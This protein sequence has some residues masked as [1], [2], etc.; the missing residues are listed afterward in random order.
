MDACWQSIGIQGDR[1]CR[2]LRAHIHCRNCPTFKDAARAFL[3]RSPEADYIDEVTGLNTNMSGGG[4]AG[5][6]GAPVMIFRLGEEW[7]ALPVRVIDHIHPPSPVRKV[8]HRLKAGFRG[9]A[10]IDGQIELCMS[11]HAVLDIESNAGERNDASR[12]WLMLKMGGERWIA[13]VDEVKGV[14]RVH[15]AQLQPL[16]ATLERSPDPACTGVFQSDGLRVSLLAPD[17]LLRRFRASLT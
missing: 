8:P 14:A 2:E 11:L 1:S 17:P 5:E 7:H 12:R 10:A 13:P 9:L 3:D 6:G 16:A 15:R 4:Q